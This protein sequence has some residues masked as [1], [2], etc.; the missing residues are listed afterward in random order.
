MK[1][2]SLLLCC[3]IAMHVSFAQSGILN[4][5]DPI[6]IYDPAHPPAI[7]PSGT[8]VKWVK[9]TTVSWNS[10]SFK[11]Y[12]YKGVA[13]RLKFPK[14]YQHNVADGKKYPIFVFF[15]GVGEKGTIYNND[16]QLYHGGQQHMNAVDNG[17]FDGFLLYP[18]TAN[19]T[20]GFEIGV[21]DEIIQKYLV[22]Q[23]KVD[24]FRV[25]VDGLSAGGK[26]TWRMLTS[27]TKTVAACLPISA[28]LS[29][30][31][32]KN[33]SSKFK[34]TP[35]W[36]F[37]GE[38]DEDPKLTT[39]N[40]EVK[41]YLDSGGNIK[42]SVYI[43]VG[44]NAWYKAWAEPDFYPFLLRAYKS[45]PWAVGGRTEFCQ[46]DVINVTVGV[47]PG[48]DKY[49]W[50]KDDVPIAN[51][52][53]NTIVAKSIGTYKC[54]ILSGTT[55]SDWSRIPLVIKNKT[56]TTAPVISLAANSSG[57]LPVL[58]GSA[59][60]MLQT[61]SNYV[62][63]AWQK[64]GA[65]TVLSTTNQFTATAPGNYTVTVGEQFGCA[66]SKSVAFKVIDGNAPNGPD[67]PTN[68]AATAL[69]TT[70]LRL[71][72]NQTSN[73]TVNETGFEIYQ[74]T[75]SSGPFSLIR[76]TASNVANYTVN[77]LN[78]GT[79]YYYILRAIGSN[80]AAPPTNPIQG[81]TLRDS[82]AP[83]APS[84]LTVTSFSQT[85]VSF[86]WH[87]STDDIGVARYDIY[88]NGVK[89]YATTDTSFSIFSLTAGNVYNIIVK[90]VDQAGNVSLPSNQATAITYLR[91]LTYKYYEGSWSNL[92]DFKALTFNKTGVVKN[93]DIS[94]RAVST[95]FGFL[96]EGF[97]K[98]T[99]GGSYT[100]RLNSD[101]GSS[102]YFNQAYNF[103]NKP[104]I[105]HDGVHNITVNKDTTVNLTAGIYP[106]AI[107][108][109]QKT[110]SF[111]CKLSWKMSQT[112]GA[113]TI[114]PDSAYTD[115]Y[116][117]NGNPPVA[118]SDLT[119]LGVLA[120]EIDLKWTDNSN[121]EQAFEI[122][123]STSAN[124]PFAKVGQA[125]ANSTSYA[126]TSGLQVSTTY[127]YRVKAIGPFGESVFND[128]ATSSLKYAYYEGAFTSLPNF[129][130]LTPIKTGSISTFSLSFKQSSVNYAATFDGV[131]NIPTTGSYT[132]YL[133][134]DDGSKL[135]IDD[136]N[137]GV[138]VDNDGLHDNSVEKSGTK[139]LSAGIHKIRVTYF[140]ASSPDN[141][142][143][144]YQ[145]PGINKQ[146]IPASVLKAD[147]VNATTTSE[148]VRTIDVNFTTKS[149]TTPAPWNNLKGITT[150]GSVFTNL[151]DEL[152]ASSGVNLKLVEAW[153]GTLTLGA[154]A[155]GKGIY[156]DEVI[157]SFYY[158]SSTEPKHVQLTGLS[159]SKKYD[160]VFFISR[161][162][163]ASATDNRTTNFTVRGTTVKL[164]ASPSNISKTVQINNISPDDSGVI[165]ITALKDPGSMYTQINAMV[166]KVHGNDGT[167]YAPSNLT[168]TSI[169]KDKIK[170]DW[171][172][173]ALDTTNFEIW[174]STS[175]A[176][177]YTKIATVAPF[178][179]TFT[180]AGLAVN[181]LFFYKVRAAKNTSFSPFSNF[182][183]AATVAYQVNIN[184]NDGSASSPAQP[185]W[186]NT[187][188][189]PEPG[190]S[191][192]NLV[193]EQG[194][195]TGISMVITDNFSGGNAFGAVTGNNSGIY[196]DN[197][198][199]SFYYL[200]F[201]DSAVFKFTKLNQSMIYN[202]VFFA[203]TTFDPNTNTVYKVGNQSVSAPAWQNTTVTQQINN[204]QPNASGEIS[205]TV[206]S[207]TGYGY[208]NAMT[209]QAVPSVVA[210]ARI[211]K[212]LTRDNNAV[213]A[214]GTNSV[215]PLTESQ[216]SVYP[217][218]FVDDINLRLRI[219]KPVAALTVR[220]TDMNGNIIHSKKYTNVPAGVWKQSL[221]LK[222][223]SLSSGMYTISVSDGST[224]KPVV[225][226]I[227]K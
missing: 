55:W 85:Q 122:W 95:N 193:D 14:T 190:Q 35:T 54:R 128:D 192:N 182:A 126:D 139:T 157:K 113:F 21:V 160:L 106:V 183:G 125:P 216:I 147:P 224:A 12:F 80:S 108:Y 98:I 210:G 141:L 90:G 17:K 119:A 161:A 101:D 89:S 215:I 131:I 180:D 148:N 75:K 62:S 143:V 149:S 121:N 227:I 212:R 146:E 200:D 73:P 69:S 58:D 178:T 43:G 152:G 136:V 93:I 221:G 225:L 154:I 9:T 28:A 205:V 177:T 64:D 127:Y 166:I 124:G 129:S 25:S 137:N 120:N 115:G 222:G 196:P 198:M 11:S 173:T 170:L 171:Q 188:Q 206:Y 22:P 78:A 23:V 79:S 94:P 103:K 31:D 176:G 211:A 102:F 84:N 179:T 96:F 39:T 153:T 51:A 114:V 201:T 151:E 145:G 163:N 44:H 87:K 142:L 81:K 209:L 223:R 207:T 74:A 92:P 42:L 158:D 218:P 15:H 186:N 99:V 123:R 220:V 49:E 172:I 169:A 150:A 59:G 13:F 199:K 50:T 6:V 88:V 135:Y 214:V 5:A 72:W 56:S 30:T 104:L 61:G 70:S 140:E 144:S 34:F 111:G 66:N 134:S 185:G 181:S 4:P 71:T 133:A 67:A 82:I 18:Q 156:P 83:T 52:T 174:R 32:I 195:N 2:V 159:S 184:F 97:L 204:I 19:D 20:W 109:F 48:F 189:P 117:V 38:I 187:N 194:A 130:T 29:Q 162:G 202:L 53:T 76:L 138:V 57:V 165:E 41:S 45:N 132:F 60:V 1:Q 175:S 10:S 105:N 26:A 37:Q 8:M 47:T 155:S 63:Y 110:G 226:K 116:V 203:S 107:A 3:V 86:T 217:N 36:Q 46:S 118:P 91:G 213:D 164:A 68:V 191:L 77:Q 208:L 7:P 168:A 27:Y 167:L 112:N 65:G 197:V 219:P 100:F 40:A 33:T 24:P 16:Y